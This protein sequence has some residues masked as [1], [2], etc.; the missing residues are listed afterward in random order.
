MDKKFRSKMNVICRI[1][2]DKIDEQLEKKF[3]LEAEKKGLIGVQGHRSV[4]KLTNQ[5]FITKYR[6]VDWDFQSIMQWKWRE[7]M[8]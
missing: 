2:K 7:L 5:W 4:R 8:L 6:L 1:T 3:I